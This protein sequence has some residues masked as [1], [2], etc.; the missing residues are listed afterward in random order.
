MFDTEEVTREMGVCEVKMRKN[1]FS[2]EGMNALGD[3]ELCFRTP[4][5][6][7]LKVK[8]IV[9]DLRKQCSRRLRAM[10]WMIESNDLEAKEH[11][12]VW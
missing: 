2:E 12:S 9:P 7:L 11:S 3:W 10:L 4:R 5:A 1:Y 8:S 6:M